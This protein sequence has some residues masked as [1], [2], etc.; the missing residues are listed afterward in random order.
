VFDFPS[1]AGKPD[2]AGDRFL[3]VPIIGKHSPADAER[4][5]GRIEGKSVSMH[6]L[7]NP[8]VR[9]ALGQCADWFA[10]FTPALIIYERKNT[11]RELSVTDTYIWL[12]STQPLSTL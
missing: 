12:D 5:S 8:F 3:A 7:P 6:P 10:F 4:L 1:Q 9:D 2:V 11:G